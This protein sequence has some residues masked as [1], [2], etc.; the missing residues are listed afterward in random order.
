M[1]EGRARQQLGAEREKDHLDAH[2]GNVADPSRDLRAVGTVF[3]RARRRTPQ[4]A[5]HAVRQSDATGRIEVWRLG[6][7]SVGMQTQRIR[8]LQRTLACMG[9]PV[10]AAPQSDIESR[11]GVKLRSRHADAD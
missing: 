10:Q 6:M 7:D 9:E 3:R 8:H 1:G 2:G 11:D 5:D 4:L